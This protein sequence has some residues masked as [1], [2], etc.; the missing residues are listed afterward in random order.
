MSENSSQISKE[1]SSKVEGQNAIVLKLAEFK[2]KFKKVKTKQE[3]FK[4]KEIDIKKP[5][6]ALKEIE[7]L[8]Q[9]KQAYLSKDYKNVMN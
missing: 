2:E 3:H 7:E 8:E 1:D 6:K 4:Q 5:L 9:A